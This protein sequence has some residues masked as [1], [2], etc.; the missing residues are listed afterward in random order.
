MHYDEI[1]FN[2]YPLS[3]TNNENS[4]SPMAMASEHHE[5]KQPKNQ[6]GDD[7]HNSDNYS[8]FT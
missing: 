7:T 5:E 4:I 2:Y 8:I 6:C 3:V 1:T